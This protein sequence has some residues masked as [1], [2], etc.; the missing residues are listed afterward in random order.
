MKMYSVIVGTEKDRNN[1]PL[2]VPGRKNALEQ[3]KRMA[4]IAFGGYTLCWGDGGWINPAGDL[5][6]EAAAIFLVASDHANDVLA[7]AQH[8]GRLFEQATVVCS[9]TAIGDGSVTFAKVDYSLLPAKI[10]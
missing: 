2:T 6:T 10:D 3:A 7:F 4:A 9:S 5:V 1:C 8:V